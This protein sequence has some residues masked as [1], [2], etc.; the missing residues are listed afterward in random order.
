M[1]VSSDRGGG[2]RSAPMALRMM[3]FT[4]VL[5]DPSGAQT[6]ETVPFLPGVA[7]AAGVRKQKS[8]ARVTQ[9]CATAPA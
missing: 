6:V 9:L 5:S 3:G 4:L 2:F 8:P 7:I 1:D